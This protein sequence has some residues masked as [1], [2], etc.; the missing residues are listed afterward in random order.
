MHQRNPVQ[1]A[2]LRGGGTENPPRRVRNSGSSLVPLPSSTRVSLTTAAG[3]PFTTKDTRKF[4]PLLVK[5]LDG[6][7]SIKIQY[8]M[9][10]FALIIPLDRER[11]E[12]YACTSARCYPTIIPRCYAM[13]R[14]ECMNCTFRSAAC[15]SPNRSRSHFVF[16]ATCDVTRYAISRG[17]RN[18]NW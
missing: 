3:V 9:V 17:C 16:G 5:T 15:P 1:K 18:I 8:E 14:H 4:C 2:C 7:P 11:G 6:V 13:V 10:S 12:F